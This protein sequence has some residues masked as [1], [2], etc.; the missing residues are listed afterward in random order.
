MAKIG[1]GAAAG[2][3]ALTGAAVLL[4]TLP[5]WVHATTPTATGDLAVSAAGTAAA[6]VAVSVGLVVIAAGL[7]LALAG[8]AVR[9]VALFV[10]IAGGVGAGTTVVGFL[11]A[12]QAVAAS[13]AADVTAVRAINTPVTV[14]FWP[15]AS[16]AALLLAVGVAA[17]L[18]LHLGHWQE[19]GRRYQPA[20]RAPRSEPGPATPQ[21]HARR[22]AMDDWDAISRGEDPT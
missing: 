16:L 17:W 13:A 10:V 19:V 7:A 2:S 15:Y 14:T 6:P 5:T 4:T 3:T 18:L 21:G 20:E 22:Q 12:P 9:V 11:R 8:R 1:R